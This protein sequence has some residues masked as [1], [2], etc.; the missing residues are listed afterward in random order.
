MTTEMSTALTSAFETV[1]SDVLGVMGDALP[2]GIAIMGA[3]LAIMLGV[4]FFR[5]IAGK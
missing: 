3:S 2:I 4:K 5:R 1:K